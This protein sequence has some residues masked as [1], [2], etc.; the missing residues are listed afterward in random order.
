M[1]KFTQIH[2]QHTRSGNSRHSCFGEAKLTTTWTQTQNMKRAQLLPRVKE[3][4]KHQNNSTKSTNT[5]EKGTQNYRKQQQK[6]IPQ[7]ANVY[8]M[9]DK[10]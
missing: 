9:Y 8:T 4:C 2:L 6:K 1:G 5:Y 3:V 7:T 10:Q